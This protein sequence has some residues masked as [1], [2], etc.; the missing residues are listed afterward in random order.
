MNREQRQ[1]L[2]RLTLDALETGHYRAAD[3]REV[4]IEA[5]QHAAHHGSLLYRPAD[6]NALGQVFGATAAAAA[7]AEVRVY[8]AP[9]LQAAQALSHRYGRLGV[10]YLASARKQNLFN[11]PTPMKLT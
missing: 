5:W 11:H 9:T 4:S 6:A 7:P 3:G 2:A 10:L 8:H 1:Q